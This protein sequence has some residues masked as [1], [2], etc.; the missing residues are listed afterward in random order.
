MLTNP[1]H[2]DRDFGDK[3]VDFVEDSDLVKPI[4]GWA[5]VYVIDS[6]IPHVDLPRLYKAADAFVLPSRGEGWGRPIVEAMA[7][8]LP[9]IVTNWSG[10]M[11]YLTEANSYPLAVDAMSE[12]FEGPFKGHLWAEPS[13]DKLRVLMR[14]VVSAPE[15]AKTKGRRAREDMIGKFSP[16][17]VAGIVTDRVLQIL[18]KTAGNI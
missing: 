7:M 3:I 8:S 5:P 1:Y 14:C 2:S 10:P 15:E 6:H 11:E 9:V 17:I 18:N 16:E 4:D 12:V 13:V